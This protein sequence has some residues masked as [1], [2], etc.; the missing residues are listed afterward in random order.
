MSDLSASP[1][2]APESPAQEKSRSLWLLAKKSAARV[3]DWFTIQPVWIKAMVVGRGT[4]DSRRWASIRSPCS[5][6]RP[7]WPRS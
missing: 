5:R 6:S 3:Q 7:P 4:A 1:Q 2:P